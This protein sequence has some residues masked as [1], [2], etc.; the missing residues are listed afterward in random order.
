MR[1]E[2]CSFLASFSVERYLFDLLVWLT[3]EQ[4]NCV[5]NFQTEGRVYGVALESINVCMNTPNYF[6]Y[7]ASTLRDV[8]KMA[9]SYS[10]IYVSKEV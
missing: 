10:N 6:D 8:G 7:V 9:K 1:E 3:T 4:T 2:F 5:K